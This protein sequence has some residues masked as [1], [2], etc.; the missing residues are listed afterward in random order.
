MIPMSRVSRRASSVFGVAALVGVVASSADARAESFTTR[1]ARYE[2]PQRFALEVRFSPYV[3]QIDEEPGLRGKPYERTFGTMPRLMFG[4]EFDW[5]ALRIPHFGSIGPG[6]GIGYT[7]MSDTARLLRD[8]SPSGDETSLDIWSTYLA[9]VL[10]IDAP[11][12]EL[13]I[14]FVPYAKAGLGLGLWRAANTG[15]TA[16]A[17]VGTG[18]VSGKGYTFGTHVALG[19]AL[20]LDFLD[21]SSSINIDQAVGINNTYFYAEYYLSMLNGIGQSNPLRVGANTWAM[22][23]AF[24]F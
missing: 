20:A 3:P 19:L 18:T 15:G 14:P 24:E 22:G 8:N 1:R 7:N 2:T 11:W 10:R 23:L 12:R 21:R 17:K 4:G 5:Q 9:A 16:E 13:G 6:L